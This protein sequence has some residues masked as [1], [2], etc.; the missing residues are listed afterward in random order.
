MNSEIKQ[1]WIKALK[2]RKY[3]QGTGWLRQV[4]GRTTLYYTH[5][6]LGVLADIYVNEYSNRFCNEMKWDDDDNNLV[7]EDE[8]VQEYN[9]ELPDW[10]LTLEEQSVLA[11]MNDEEDKSFSE[12]ATWIEENIKETKI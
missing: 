2:S 4:E 9:S 8:L 5:C 6:C 7:V 12:I 11:T 10:E 1:K 3:T